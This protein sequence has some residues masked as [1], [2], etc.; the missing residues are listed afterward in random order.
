MT[1]TA[2]TRRRIVATLQ[3]LGPQAGAALRRALRSTE[4]DGLDA[5][6]ADLTAAGRVIATPTAK[7]TRYRLAS[8][9]LARV[10]NHRR[11]CERCGVRRRRATGPLCGT[12]LADPTPTPT[13]EEQHG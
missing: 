2:A 10:P 1:D 11:W 8:A 13:R 4:R 9:E 6:L 7:G 3:R 5:A 12:C